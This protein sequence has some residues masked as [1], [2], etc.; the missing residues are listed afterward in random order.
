MAP[1]SFAAASGD[2]V[3]DGSGGTCVLTGRCNSHYEGNPVLQGTEY[4]KYCYKWAELK[5]PNIPT[6]PAFNNAAIVQIEWKF[7]AANAK[8]TDGNFCI[9]DVAFCK[10]DACTAQ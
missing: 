2:T 6:P 5:S 8:S 10:A 4:K 3:P 1:W 9:D 7:P